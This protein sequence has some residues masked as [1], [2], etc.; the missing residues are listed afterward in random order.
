[1][2]FCDMVERL[3]IPYFIKCQLKVLDGEKMQTCIKNLDMVKMFSTEFVD[4]KDIK[5][6]NRNQI[7]NK[8]VYVHDKKIEVKAHNINNQDF[9]LC[10]SDCYLGQNAPFFRI[11]LNVSKNKV[12]FAMYEA[13]ENSFDEACYIF[14]YSN[15]SRLDKAEVIEKGHKQIVDLAEIEA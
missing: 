7:L 13:K 10:R 4:L 2:L 8:N 14:S 1:M 5:E 6:F 3:E 9:G 11:G 12:F 15:Q